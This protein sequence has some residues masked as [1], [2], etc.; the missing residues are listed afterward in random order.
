MNWKDDGVGS[1]ISQAHSGFWRF[2]ITG[3]TSDNP[4][5]FY[6]SYYDA[7]PHNQPGPDIRGGAIFFKGA[8]EFNGAE[9]TPFDVVQRFAYGSR[10]EAERA[11]EGKLR[12]LL[13]T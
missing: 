2:L 7:R 8:D 1:P 12:E 3:P 13:L 6:A 11:C 9:A 10:A 4:P 5:L